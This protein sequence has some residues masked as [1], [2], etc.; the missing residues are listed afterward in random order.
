V[1]ATIPY[2]TGHRPEKDPALHIVEKFYG[3]EA[4]GRTAPYIEHSTLVCER[5]DSLPAFARISDLDQDSLHH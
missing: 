5:R 1:Q 4:A 2:A 3:R